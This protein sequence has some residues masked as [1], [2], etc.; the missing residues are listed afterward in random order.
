M[1]KE[2]AE[3]RE[4]EE[5]DNLPLS[6]IKIDVNLSR[7]PFFA[8][9]CQRLKDELEKEWRF[10]EIRDG[11]RLDLLWRVMAIPRYGY[12]GFFAKKVHRAIEYLLTK[13]GFPVPEHLDFSFHEIEEVLELEHSGRVYN[14]IKQAIMSITF[15]GIESRGTFCYLENGEKKYVHDT[16]HFYERAVFT[17]E[18]LPDGTMTDKNRIYFSDWYLKSLNSLYIKPLD[19]KYWKS[20]RSSVAGRLYEY[21]SYTSFAT[22]CRPFSIKYHRLCEL[23][24]IT[25]QPYFSKAK[26]CLKGPHKELIQT[27]FLKRVIWRESKTESKEWVVVY[28]F[29]ERAKQELQRGFQD[30]R[31]YPDILAVETA[32]VLPEIE[33]ELQEK[34]KPAQEAKELP[35]LA[36]ELHERGIT[37]STAINLTRLFPE[38]YIEEKI[39]MFDY[40]RKTRSHLISRNP[41]GWLRSAIEEDYELEEFEEKLKIHEAEERRK[42]LEHRAIEVIDKRIEEAIDNFPDRDK[43][44]EKKVDEVIRIRNEMIKNMPSKRPYTE[45]EISKMRQEF[46]QGYPLSFEERRDWL[47]HQPEYRVDAIVKELQAEE[48][49]D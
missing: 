34:S 15:A 45:E 49:N 23:L 28:H 4:K 32:E 2:K 9:H 36:F 17:G 7:L 26:Y 6:V 22:K 5:Q 29:G 1:S 40:L 38:E 8:L 44:V 18:K 37:K 11:K 41:A 39:K 16:F 14:D 25:P 20:L 27:G 21:I 46:S 30:D 13:K 12:P 48:K 43:W 42:A 35:H 47:F 31:D 19:F 3:E 24:P 10:S 33:E